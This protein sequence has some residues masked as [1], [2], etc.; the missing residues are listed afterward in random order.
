MSLCEIPA[1]RNS[2]VSKDLATLRTVPA[3]WTIDNYVG[4]FIGM[5]QWMQRFG[6]YLMALLR[7]LLSAQNVY[8]YIMYIYF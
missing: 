1:M 6:G 2:I 4:R 7:H 8:R 3:A 5:W